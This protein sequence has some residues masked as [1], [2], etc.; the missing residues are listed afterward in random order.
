[1]DV[2]VSVSEVEV[3]LFASEF[4]V[5]DKRAVVASVSRLVEDEDVEVK[6]SSVLGLDVDRTN[7]ECTEVDCVGVDRFLDAGVEAMGN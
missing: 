1:M 7:V 4:T 3:I 2:S 6:V 5:V